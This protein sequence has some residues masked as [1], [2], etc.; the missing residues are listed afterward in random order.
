MA[1]F[2]AGR[3]AEFW[4]FNE[5]EGLADGLRR[6]PNAETV[7]LFRVSEAVSPEGQGANESA[8]EISGL[9][10][11]LVAREI[12]GRLRSMSRI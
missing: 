10:I 6:F 11:D 12:V 8:S 9:G 3:R 1:I 2:E 5:M 7:R 4:V